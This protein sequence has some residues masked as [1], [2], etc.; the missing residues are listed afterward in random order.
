MIKK[1][2]TEISLNPKYC[3]ITTISLLEFNLIFKKI[4]ASRNKK[5]LKVPIKLGRTRIVVFT[6]SNN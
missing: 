6:T 2:K 5:E 1:I 3:F 4:L